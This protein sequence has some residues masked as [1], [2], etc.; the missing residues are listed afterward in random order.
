M[1]II[2]FLILTF[3]GPLYLITSGQISFFGDYRTANRDSANLAPLAAKTPDAVV[4][5]YTARAFDWNGLFSVHTWIATK[6]ANAKDYTVYQVIGW[7][8]YRGLE[9][10]FISEDIPDRNWFAQ[11]PWLLYDLRG[12]KAAQLI[13][14]IKAAA[15]AYPY[16]KDY[17]LWPGP[18]SNSFTAFVLRQIPEL[19]VAMPPNA[20]G[21]DFLCEGK[22]FTTAVSHTGYQLS[23]FGALGITVAREEGLEINFLGLV[24][25]FNPFKLSIKLPCIGEI[26]WRKSIAGSAKSDSPL[27]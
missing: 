6:E 10:L 19:H 20:V 2:I 7:R 23:L 24:Y 12:E 22:I 17:T 1:L 27:S 15:A 11:K 13:P 18:N 4:Q 21:K 3:I 5:V 9:P 8:R 25:G 26:S 16:P 14:K